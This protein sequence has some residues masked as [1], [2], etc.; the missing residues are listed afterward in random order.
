MECH[1]FQLIVMMPKQ[2][3]CHWCDY[4]KHPNQGYSGKWGA[5]GYSSSGNGYDFRIT[6]SNIQTEDTGVYYS[7]YYQQPGTVRKALTGT[8]TT[9]L[10]GSPSR[11]SAGG[12]GSDFTLTVTAVQA[13]DAGI[14]YCQSDQALSLWITFGGGTEVIV[15]SGVSVKPTLSLLPPSSEEL[16]KGS[17]TLSCLLSSYS[18]KGALVTWQ[19]DGREVTAGVLTGQ[20][21][22]SSTGYSR[23]SI[24][25]L[26]KASW[27]EG[28]LYTCLVAHDGRRQSTELRRTQCSG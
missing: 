15:S 6:I 25:T 11:F 21:V 16:S 27:D 1:D 7:W 20:E 17:A 10:A 24:L 23:S 22:W 3:N 18:P 4:Q 13:E 19:K 14:S 9:L 8:G 26:S 5:G 28:D 12:S 2:I